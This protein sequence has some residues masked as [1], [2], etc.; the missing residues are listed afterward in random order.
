[1]DPIAQRKIKRLVFCVME[2]SPDGRFERRNERIQKFAHKRVYKAFDLFQGVE[3]SWVI[4]DLNGVSS[5]ERSRLE[6]ECRRLTQ[7]HNR[8][9]LGVVSSW[10]D[11]EQEKLCVITEHTTSGSLK[12]Y[13]DGISRL[14]LKIVKKWARQILEGLAFLHSQ[15]PPIVHRDLKL[16]NIYI[17]SNTGEIRIGDFGLAAC[18]CRGNE[19]TVMGSP[20]FMAPELFESEC[21]TPGADIY[22][23]GMVMLE[24]VTKQYPYA[25]CHSATQVWRRVSRGI[26]PRALSLIDPADFET[27][28]FIE[29][30]LRP[31]DTRPTADDLLRHPYLQNSNDSPWNDRIIVLAHVDQNAQSRDELPSPRG[32][33]RC[34]TCGGNL[35]HRIRKKIQT[36]FVAGAH[37]Q[38]VRTAEV[39]VDSPLS[40]NVY[41]DAEDPESSP[42]YDPSVDLEDSN[43][44]QPVKDALGST[45]ALAGK[46]FIRS[47]SHA[48]AELSLGERTLTDCKRASSPTTAVPS[49]CN[50]NHEAAAAAGGHVKGRLLLPLRKIAD[51]NGPGSLLPLHRQFDQHLQAPHRRRPFPVR[52]CSSVANCP[53]SASSCPKRLDS[54]FARL[55]TMKKVLRRSR[56]AVSL[57][58]LR[59]EGANIYSAILSP[60]SCPKLAGQ[61][62]IRPLHF[63]GV[64]SP[65]S[66]PKLAD[67]TEWTHVQLQALYVYAPAAGVVLGAG[68]EAGA[69]GPPAK[70]QPK[71]PLERIKHGFHTRRAL[72]RCPEKILLTSFH[73]YCSRCLKGDTCDSVSGPL[74]RE[75]S[76]ENLAHSFHTYCSTLRCIKSRHRCASDFRLRN[77]SMATCSRHMSNF[78]LTWELVRIARSIS[79]S[80]VA[81]LWWSAPH[82]MEV[83]VLLA[84]TP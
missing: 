30:C 78:P 63:P 43:S 16:D 6:N 40:A 12:S 22:A 33:E 67:Q 64:W 59:R 28:A 51:A 26:K 50:L 46:D 84:L 37:T 61:T 35:K 68:A 34:R 77:A 54:S 79:R 57:S 48:K 65:Q 72:G 19:K 42:D 25:E 27:R 73:T 20:E 53:Q 74:N 10:V 15:K 5:T 18:I 69:A 58:S 55:E 52:S 62:S 70:A 80:R 21:F 8:Y 49:P 39:L 75:V 3:T 11:K 60:K 81:H 7:I 47:H 32:P 82:A 23:F 56:S 45:G 2:R 9:I 24:L 66:C 17:N 29:F 38:V 44:I 76:R 31:Q 83:H 36:L 71:T 13:V 4:I 14:K 41:F 1:M